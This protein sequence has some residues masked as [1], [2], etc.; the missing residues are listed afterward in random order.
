MDEG[1]STI[2][3]GVERSAVSRKGLHLLKVNEDMVSSRLERESYKCLYKIYRE[4]GEE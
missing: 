4:E 1:S 2:L 3:Y